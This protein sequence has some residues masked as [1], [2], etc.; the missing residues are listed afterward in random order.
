MQTHHNPTSRLRPG[1]F[2]TMIAA[3]LVASGLVFAMPPGGREAVP[4]V[5][6]ASSLGIVTAIDNA[7]IVADGTVAGAA[8]DVVI[9]LDRDLDPAIDGYRLEA[10][11]TLRVRLP[12]AFRNTGK[13][14]LADAFSRDDC[15]PG[16]L[17]CTTAVL[18]RGWQ[19]SPIPP[20]LP[21]KPVGKGKVIYTLGLE[22]ERTVVFTARVPI[23]PGAP[24][25]RSVNPG[26]KQ[27]HLLLKGFRN[28][29]PGRYPVAVEIRPDPADPERHHRGVGTL[30]VTAKGRPTL[31]MTRAF[32]KTNPRYLEA[33]PS[34]EVAVDYLLWDRDGKP[35]D[36]VTLVPTG[37]HTAL[38]QRAG[39]KVGEVTIEPPEGAR[40]HGLRAEG[41]SFVAKAPVL[42]VP[43]ARLR[44]L[45]R[46]GDKPGRY[47]LTHALADGTTEISYLDVR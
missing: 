28:P 2:A 24:L 22:E 34:A 12:E 1:E 33:R 45:V 18:L 17:D 9:T 21:P 23:C 47:R 8:T 44:V 27:V 37:T 14:A 10:G 13:P 40:G 35:L 32:G 16:R 42:G 26:I 41:R 19:Q 39:K 15:V 6:P 4:S 36:G 25:P 20:R 30:E 11:G 31:A 38:L 46:A 7:P 43:T 29:G 5:G 3:S